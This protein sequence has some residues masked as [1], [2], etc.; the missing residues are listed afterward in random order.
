MID[1]NGSIID[2]FDPH[3]GDGSHE[4]AINKDHT[5]DIDDFIKNMNDDDSD[6]SPESTSEGETE[7]KTN[8]KTNEG[9]QAAARVTGDTGDGQPANTAAD[10]AGSLSE[11]TGEKAVAAQTDNKETDNKDSGSSLPFIIGGIVIVAVA[12]AGGYAVA[13][14]KRK[15]DGK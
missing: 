14:K 12:A 10:K 1:V 15:G 7:H 4:Q 2:S 13:S 11:A 9:G 8:N 5:S 6:H 3:G